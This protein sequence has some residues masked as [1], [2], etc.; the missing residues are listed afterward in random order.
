MRLLYVAN[1]RMPT[2]R[3]H[4]VQIVKTC[5]ALTKIGMNIEL[6][7]PRRAT[8]IESDTFGYYGTKEQFP[9]RKVPVVDTVSWGRPGFILES[10]SF[11][12]SAVRY[13]RREDVCL[14]G[15][16]ELILVFLSLFTKR[17][18]I[19]ESHTGAWNYF[20]RKA[21]R[22][23]KRVVVISRGLRDFYIARG[24]PSEK[25]IVAP[26]A[27]DLEDFEKVETKEE[28][29]ER[30]GISTLKKVALYVGDFGG[31]KGTDTLFG[32]ST[33]LPGDISIVAIG[34]K[35][36]QIALLKR[37]YPRVRFLGFRPYS[38]LPNNQVAAD[39][40]VL[41]N[42]ATDTIST[43]FTSPLKLFTYMASGRPIVA[44]DIPSIREVLPEEGAYWCEPDSARDLAR[45]I[46]SAVGDSKASE[47]A[48]VARMAVTRYTWEARARL[49]S[50]AFT[51]VL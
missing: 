8:P 40:L 11:A 32:A 12:F 37:K 24:V 29:R 47:R 36:E 2:E 9:I 31:W 43:S 4:G 28:A 5:A 27:V 17:E 50:A 1:V 6:L 38:E 45:A 7:V 18:I 22:R 21:A 41:P 25:I 51:Y 16:D 48:S 15:R 33:F 42:T 26:D 30:L 10:L 49:I 13:A 19:W 44:S 46:Q 39:V 23:S 14:Y 20:A 3:A 35:D 34:G